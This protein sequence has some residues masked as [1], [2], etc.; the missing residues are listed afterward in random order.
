MKDIHYITSLL[1]FYLKGEISSD[2]DFIRFKEPNTI[3]GLIPLGAKNES[4]AVNQISTVQTNMKMKFGK[5][6]LG[7]FICLLAL[8]SFRESFL[9]GLILLVIGANNVLD[10]FEVDL[11]HL[12]IFRI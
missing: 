6:I 2:A 4:V 9:L 12:Y 1:T 8:T 3:L 5:L 10:A 11:Q 7:A